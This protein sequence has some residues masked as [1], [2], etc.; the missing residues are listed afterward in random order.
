MDT[1]MLIIAANETCPQL[2]TKEHLVAMEI[3]NDD[4]KT[5]QILFKIKLTW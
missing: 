3:V 1:T 4:F 5:I 2:Q